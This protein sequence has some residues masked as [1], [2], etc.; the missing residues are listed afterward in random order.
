MYKKCMYCN[1]PFES[2]EDKNYCPNCKNHHV[3]E[4]M[5]GSGATKSPE[6]HPDLMITD[7]VE[8]KQRH[9]EERKF[10][11]Y[12]ILPEASIT[13]VAGE[14]GSGKTMFCMG[15][16]DALTKGHGFGPWPNQVGDHLKCLYVDGEM[17]PY[18]LKPRLEQMDTNEN[19]NVYSMA[20][21]F[22]TNNIR[23]YLTDEDF[24][25][26]LTYE[27]L[28]NQFNFVVIDNLASLAPGI[29]ENTKKAYDPINQWLL[30]LRHRGITIIV[31]HHLGKSGEQRGTS[32]REDAV[33][34]ILY[35]KKPKRHNASDGARFS[36]HFD[37][38]R[39]RVVDENRDLLKDRVL[40]YKQNGE[41]QW[42]WNDH[43]TLIE[44][45]REL[46]KDLVESGET[47]SKLAEKHHMSQ[48]TVSRRKQKFLEMGYIVAGE[49]DGK[50]AYTDEGQEWLVRENSGG[51]AEET[52]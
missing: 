50:L 46:L 5:F 22:K 49:E 40:W 47:L 12:P 26:S 41:G 43:D 20:D 14:D 42:E 17:H 7:S 38:F 36:L 4:H 11:L 28:V 33:D 21:T 2:E 45:S 3:I 34:S 35:I 9:F 6:Q 32:S 24:R 31:V 10:F 44:N 8:W 52:S 13:L 30:E 51:V 16:M 1:A 48:P 23:G 25:N 27:L 39:G 15:M 37:K 18:D 29:D 19:F